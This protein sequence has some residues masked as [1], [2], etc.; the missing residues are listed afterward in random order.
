MRFVVSL[1][2]LFDE[3]H[4]GIRSAGCRIP[5]IAEQA[6]ASESGLTGQDLDA[7]TAKTLL[8]ALAVKVDGFGRTGTENGC[9]DAGRKVSIA[10]AG[11]NCRKWVHLILCT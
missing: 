5:V 6:G 10:H 8:D 9:K 2:Q 11:I 1:I 4:D 3:L 7:V